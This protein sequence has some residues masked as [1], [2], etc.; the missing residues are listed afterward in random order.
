MPD[1]IIPIEAGNIYHIY[2]RGVN[3]EPIFFSEQNYHYFLFKM[4][5]YF[6]N[7]AV[8]LAYC[9][10]PNH[11]HLIAQIQSN[12][13]IQK[14]LL[15]F[16]ISYTRSVNIDQDRNGPLFQGRY[17]ANLIADDSYLLDCIKYIHLN[18]VKAGLV[19]TPKEWMFSSHRD[20]VSRLDKSFLDYST[21]MQHFDSISE[22]IKYI[23]SDIQTYQSKYFVQ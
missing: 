9:L 2:N 20:Y 18:P 19:K 6:R 3:K 4:A 21:V 13:F 7:K 5:N 11:F 15:P 22:F 14:S 17:Q 1:R 16:L 12:E 10:M 8:I 23:E